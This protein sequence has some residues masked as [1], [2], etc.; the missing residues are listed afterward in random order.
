MTVKKM[1]SYF[2][3]Y[4]AHFPPWVVLAKCV[5]AA[6]EFMCLAAETGIQITLNLARREWVHITVNDPQSIG[7]DNLNRF[8]MATLDDINVPKG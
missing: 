2:N 8:A 5:C 4:A 6:P 7:I 3:L 1:P